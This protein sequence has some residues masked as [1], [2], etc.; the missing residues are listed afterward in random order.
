MVHAAYLLYCYSSNSQLHR[1][2]F[3]ISKYFYKLVT[4]SLPSESPGKPHI[5]LINFKL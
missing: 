4:D 2:F 3:N 1:G 5:R